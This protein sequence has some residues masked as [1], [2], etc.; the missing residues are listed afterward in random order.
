MC[1]CRFTAGEIGV[2]LPGGIPAWV[3][4]N[5]VVWTTMSAI[6]SVGIM[7]YWKNNYTE[8]ATIP[9]GGSSN[10]RANNESSV[11][12]PS[13]AQYCDNDKGRAVEEHDLAAG[14]G[15]PLLSKCEIL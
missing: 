15:T 6:L 13:T 10:D 2:I 14:T 9:S 12:I 7:W 3:A 5:F 8:K 1:E 11:S 4:T